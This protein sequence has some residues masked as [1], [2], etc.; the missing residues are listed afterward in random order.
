MLD[1]TGT[2]GTWITFVEI[3]PAPKTKRWSVVNKNTMETL[4]TVSWFGRWRR[5]AFTPMENTVFEQDC[6]RDIADF[7][8]N[9]TQQHSKLREIVR[10]SK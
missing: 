9:Q 7:C 10:S 8:V 3:D 2:E 4:G 6:L 5:Y 1:E